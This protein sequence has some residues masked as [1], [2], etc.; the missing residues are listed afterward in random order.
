MERT[1]AKAPSVKSISQKGPYSYTYTPDLKPIARIKT[2]QIIE[3][4]TPDAFENKLRTPKDLCT[5]K[6]QFPF[7]NPQVGPIYV[8]GAEPG[9]ILAVKIHD[10]IPDRDYVVTGLVPNFGALTGTN[11]TAILS[12]PLLEETRILPLVDGHVVFNEMIRIPYR[13]FMGTIGVAP[14]IES[15]SSLVPSYYGGNMDCVDTCPGNEV[16]FPVQVD[17]A[18]F[19]TGDAHATQGD[20]EITGVAAELAARVVLSFRVIKKK[21]ISWPRIVSDTHLM[22]C[23][24]ARP[25]EDAARIAWKELVLWLSEDYQ[26]SKLD[27]YHLLGQVGQMRVGNMV[28]PNYTM[29][30]KIERKYVER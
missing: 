6:C 10:I 27:A 14:A 19:F 16:W 20:G 29:V 9:D 3:L 7:T 23:G 18:H 22:T 13:P 1:V 11:T 28:D 26:L 8:Q 21:K 24:S 15:I 12:D 2:G 30:A 25:L 4:R 17:G 5:K